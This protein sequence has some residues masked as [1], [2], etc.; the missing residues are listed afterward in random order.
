[1]RHLDPI[2]AD[3]TVAATLPG[4]FYRDEEIYRHTLRAVFGEAWHLVTV[5]EVPRERGAAPWTLLPGALDVPLLITRDD[6]GTLR[7]LSNVCT[8]RGA[9]LLNEPCTGSSV[10]CPYHGRR[11]GLDG[12]MNHMP[13]FQQ[14]KDFPREADHLPVLPMETIGPL[15]F[16]TLTP[17][18]GA[19]A[20]WQRWMG[21]A[22]QRIPEIVWGDLPP[23][24]TAVRHYDLPAHWAL[25]CDNYLE[26]FHIP[27]VHP[28][29]AAVLDYSAYTT[30]VLPQGVLQ[31]GIAK[32]DEACFDVPRDHV[33]AGARV[34]AYYLW[35]FPNL[36]LNFYP[37][38]LSL[39][40]VEPLGIANTRIT[41]AT[42]VRDP[43]LLDQGAGAGLHTVEMEDQAV[44]QRVQRGIASPLYDR[45][46]YSPSREQ[47][48]HHFHRLILEALRPGAP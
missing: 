23:A 18:A 47:G 4:S 43:S 13:E 5:P 35:L 42:Y 24:P 26:G 2:D 1:M 27:F 22:A 46:R 9:L 37:W 10:R 36:M 17:V 3:I 6:D 19:A 25:Y 20:R 15:S 33:D 34:A 45:G 16:V 29:L 8:H 41:Y 11:F 38:G 14:A 12:R 7:C 44:I 30:E 32:D 31:I 48:V 40:L 21:S 39:N 28:G